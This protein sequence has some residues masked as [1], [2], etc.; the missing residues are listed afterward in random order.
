MERRHDQGIL[1]FIADRETETSRGLTPVAFGF[2]LFGLM[3]N[4]GLGHQ[5]MTSIY[6][7]VLLPT[8]LFEKWFHQRSS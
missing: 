8:W 3:K 2:G 1:V 4:R 7:Y 5:S 6:I